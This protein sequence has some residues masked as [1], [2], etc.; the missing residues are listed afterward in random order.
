MKFPYALLAG[1][2]SA[3]FAGVTHA[4]S[5][6]SEVNAI[7]HIEVKGR[8]AQFYRID[9][10]AMATKTP[11]A[12]L[13]I[14][15]SVQVL[16]RELIDDQ[17]ARQTT[18]LY[19]SI[20]GVS[21][22]SYSGVTARG[23]RQDQV[24]YDGVQ[25][26]PYSGF[27]IPQLFN[28]ERVEVL[29]GPSSM[30]YGGGQPGALINYV[31]KKPR[32]EDNTEISLF[33]G[34][35]NRQGASV[36]AIG[37]VGDSETTAFRLGAF[38]ED[39]DTF[40]NNTNEKNLLISG[41]LTFLLGEH[42]E[43]TLQYDHIDQ[44]LQGHRIRGVPVSDDGHFLTTINYNANE[45][46]DFQDLEADA[47]QAILSHDFG[48]GLINTTVVRDLDNERVQNYHENRGLLE[49]GRT[50]TREY[51]DQTRTNE[52][53]SFTTDFVLETELGGFEHT[54]LFGGDYFDVDTS[55]TFF[56]ARGEADNV[57]NIDIIDPVYGADA[58]TYALT[59]LARPDTAF[60]RLGIYVQ[61]Q[62]RFNANWLALVGV[63]YDDFED[64]V[65]GV[66]QIVSDNQVTPRIGLIYQPNTSTSL[67]ANVTRG[68]LPQSFNTQLN[69]E[70]DADRARQFEPEESE[71][72]EFGIKNEWLDNRFVSSLTLYDITK[73]NVT[74]GNPL[75]TGAGDGIPAIVQI[76]EVTSEGVELD[77]VGDIM[78][79][80]TGTFNYAYNNTK[81]TGG[82]PNSISNAVGTEFANAPKHTVGVWTRFDFPAIES[83]FA[84][85][86]DHVGERV[87]LSGQTVRSFT[88]WDASWSSTI[89]G[90]ELQFN[91]RNLFDKEYATSGFIARNGH[92]PG[93]PRTF[94]L[95]INRT[96]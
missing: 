6:D 87:S 10:S 51:R 18:E 29:K 41:G 11:T 57:P 35:Y 7:E 94:M 13:D 14:P 59:D 22:F 19:R 74:V 12:F 83:A 30:L 50:M 48:D 16:S 64:S 3:A 2:V 70:G 79:N 84:I 1:A 65:E 17:A 49:D 80:W 36:D 76:G 37:S 63:R 55:F 72:I 33:G 9:E 53:I 62:I 44:D 43:L 67:F 58:S 21:Q 86:V 28:V 45:P 24:R 20:S 75:D 40:R 96:L 8:A 85:G 23:F 4:Q 78:E 82:A 69:A 27:S 32:F 60:E 92:F 68:F 89:A 34:N 81:I 61:D 66:D 26:D 31:S 90:V 42:T 25:G 93:E 46:T 73:D 91:I 56:R 95:Q 15:Q 88:V 38:Y 54:L 39:R 71:Q 5:N 47:F 52:E 77:V